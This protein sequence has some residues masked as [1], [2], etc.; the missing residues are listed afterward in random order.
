[1]R[2]L[3]DLKRTRVSSVHAEN[4]YRRRVRSDVA[5]RNEKHTERLVSKKICTYAR[6]VLGPPVVST[7]GLNVS[8]PG[9]IIAQRHEAELESDT[10]EHV[11]VAFM[12]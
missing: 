2:A 7:I 9:G 5:K 10:F 3:W 6:I 1:M 4:D 8:G 12:C 11:S